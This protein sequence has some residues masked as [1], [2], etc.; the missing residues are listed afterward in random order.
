MIKK[1]F[2]KQEHLIR[3]ARETYVTPN[4]ASEAVRPGR[5]SRAQSLAFII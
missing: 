2:K 5:Q 3:S 1:K 4:R